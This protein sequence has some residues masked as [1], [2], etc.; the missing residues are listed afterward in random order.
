MLANLNKQ[1]IYYFNDIQAPWST[2]NT[3]LQYLHDNSD[4][5]NDSR[6]YRNYL[7]GGP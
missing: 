3:T 1:T 4:N 2:Y 6:N 5:K 7:H